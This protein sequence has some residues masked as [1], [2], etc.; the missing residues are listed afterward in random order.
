ME[1]A[2][3]NSEEIDECIYLPILSEKT[4]DMKICLHCCASVPGG[5][6]TQHVARHNRGRGK[7]PMCEGCNMSL[8]TNGGSTHRAS[9][10]HNNVRRRL[11][12]YFCL[13]CGGVFDAATKHPHAEHCFNFGEA[14]AYFKI[15][16][17]ALAK[18]EDKNE[19]YHG[20]V[21]SMAGCA[22]TNN[23][24]D[25][26]D[27]L[28]VAIGLGRFVQGKDRIV[29]K[30]MCMPHLNVHLGIKEGEVPP[31][32]E[33]VKINPVDD[34]G[35]KVE[36]E[37]C[38]NLNRMFKAD[39]EDRDLYA[40]VVNK[41]DYVRVM[42]TDQRPAPA[43]KKIVPLGEADALRKKL[44]KD[45]FQSCYNFDS[46]SLCFVLKPGY[47]EKT[48]PKKA[49]AAAAAQSE[50]ESE[51]EEEDDQEEAPQQSGEKAEKSETS[52]PKAEAAQSKTATPS[53]GLS[54]GETVPGSSR[55]RCTQCKRTY[56]G[57]SCSRC[58]RK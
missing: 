19:M 25:K 42:Y 41:N 48:K 14:R 21:N 22:L 23:K 32:C 10:H 3:C 13:E 8:G 4:P 6:L 47:E 24:R 50:A 54:T 17:P 5:N 46:D 12:S 57:A 58:N 30:T 29:T 20:K 26:L 52:E 33:I 7:D 35:N 36:C 28:E 43:L 1:R 11:R 51:D 53:G 27:K 55:V 40:A 38:K 37:V 16:V 45:L 56:T 34:R 39:T 2:F 49:P 9:G 18:T 15:A 31:L 44:G